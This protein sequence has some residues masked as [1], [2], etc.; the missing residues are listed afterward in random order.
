MSLVV[1]EN[2]QNVYRWYS[3]IKMLITTDLDSEKRCNILSK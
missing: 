3:D 1:R 2:L